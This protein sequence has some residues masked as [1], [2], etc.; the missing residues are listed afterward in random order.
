MTAI[1]KEAYHLTVY[2]VWHTAGQSNRIQGES[3]GDIA[4]EG[5]WLRNSDGKLGQS[6]LLAS[7]TSTSRKFRSTNLVLKAS[8]NQKEASF[9]RERERESKGE[10]GLSVPG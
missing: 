10:C 6:E 9:R 3:A 7:T 8:I 2:N 5:Y 4:D 1:F